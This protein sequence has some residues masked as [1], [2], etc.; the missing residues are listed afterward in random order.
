L[1]IAPATRR[2][3]L[4]VAAT[5]LGGAAFGSVGYATLVEPENI[6]LERLDIHLPQLSEHF[7]GLK[8]ALLS[9]FHYGPFTGERQ[10]GRAVDRANAESPHVVV[11]TGDFISA[12]MFLSHRDRSLYPVLANAVSCANALAGLRAPLGVFAVLGNHD[13]AVSSAHVTEALQARNIHVLANVNRALE[14]E[15]GRLWLAG[16]P[17]ALGGGP[18]LDLALRGIPA[19]EPTVLLVHEPD[20]ADQAARHPVHLQLSGHSHGGQMRVPLLGSP[21]LPP[22]ARKYPYG[23][24]RVGQMQLYTNRGIGTILLP[25]RLCAPPEVTLLTLHSAARTASQ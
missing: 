19:G 11:L 6:E 24:Y 14:R 23:Y 13:V 8:I 17:D 9:D 4:R 5:A 18:R 16:V 1:Q 7:D 25:M 22:L 3:F 15:S 10:I 21:Y 2:Q 20:F 12:P